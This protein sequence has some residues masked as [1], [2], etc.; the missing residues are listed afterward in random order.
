MAT[1]F[2]RTLRSLEAQGPTRALMG[3]VSLTLIMG[4]WVA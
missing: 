1:P 4:G 3:I 2:P